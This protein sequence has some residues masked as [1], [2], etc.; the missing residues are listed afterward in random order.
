[1]K[2]EY[3]NLR[4]YAKKPDNTTIG[5]HTAFNAKYSISKE[6]NVFGEA[7]LRIHSN[8]FISESAVDYNPVRTLNFRVGVSD[9]IK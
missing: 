7:D 6:W 3:E 4:I 5:L 2:P 9:D 8:E 1:M